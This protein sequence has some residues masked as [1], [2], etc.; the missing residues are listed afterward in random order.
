MT[1][2]KVKE[3]LTVD[4]MLSA[5]LQ[6]KLGDV[7]E[8]ETTGAYGSVGELYGVRVEDKKLILE[9]DLMSG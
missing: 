4:A 3:P 9:T 1:D 8:I 5:L 7:N 2:E 6:L